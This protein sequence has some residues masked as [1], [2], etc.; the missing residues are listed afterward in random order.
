MCD[1]CQDRDLSCPSSPRQ[2]V[3]RS[4]GQTEQAGGGGAGADPLAVRLAARHARRQVR[5]AIPACAGWTGLLSTQRT[6]EKDQP[7]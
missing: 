2:E 1:M 5:Q 6:R 4:E 3:D 7:T